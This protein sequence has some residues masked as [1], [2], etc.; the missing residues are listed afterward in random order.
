MTPSEITNVLLGLIEEKY[1]KD[2]ETLR[3]FKWLAQVP[4]SGSDY[5]KNRNVYNLQDA[6]IERLETEKKECY[7]YVQKCYSLY[8]SQ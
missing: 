4:P 7:A 5:L 8:I 6:A 1:K 2:E 3:A